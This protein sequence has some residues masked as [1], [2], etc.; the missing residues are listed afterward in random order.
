HLT[1]SSSASLK[2]NSKRYGLDDSTLHVYDFKRPDT[3]I[4]DLLK[5]IDQGF[6]SCVIFN[7]FER[8]PEYKKFHDWDPLQASEYVQRQNQGHFYLLHRALPK[9]IEKKLGHLILI[10]SVSSTAGT[11]NYSP[12]CV[13][14]AGLEALFKNLA[15]EYGADNINANIVRLGFFDTSRTNKVWSNERY[16]MKIERKIPSA[17]LGK[18]ADVSPVVSMLLQENGYIN[19]ATLDVSGGLPLTNFTQ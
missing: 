2:K 19:G 5:K 18:A 14:K 10:S 16:R 6:F 1:F 17:R 11:N 8:L 12:Y 9:M 13:A 3:Q 15:V 7:A 4:G